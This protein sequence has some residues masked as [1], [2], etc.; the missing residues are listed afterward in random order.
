MT[1]LIG[2]LHC[3]WF[4][5]HFILCY[6]IIS[7]VFHHA[8]ASSANLEHSTLTG[9]HRRLVSLFQTKW[10]LMH[11]SWVH[12]FCHSHTLRTQKDR[13]S[14]E[15]QFSL[16]FFLEK[17][18]K[19]RNRKRKTVWLCIFFRS[20]SAASCTC[21]V[22]VVVVRRL[23]MQNAKYEQKK[24]ACRF[25]RCQCN[26]GWWTMSIRFGSKALQRI[27]TTRFDL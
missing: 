14:V 7:T 5:H 20:T 8:S 10:I 4:F 9:R 18:K 25:Y 21:D 11:I 19:Q 17:K 22:D 13:V 24:N 3:I 6:G 15:C 27:E 12:C 2:T 26:T 16:F 1:P 23:L